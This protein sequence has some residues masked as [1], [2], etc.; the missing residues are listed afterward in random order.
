V[1]PPDLDPAAA[2]RRLVADI[3]GLA[4]SAFAFG[5]VYGLAALAAGFSPPDAIATSLIVFSGAA[6]FAA[7]GLVVA[8]AG[9][10]L[11]VITTLF[12]NLRHLLYAA[13]LR[14]SV[15]TRSAI[16]RAGMAHVLTDE[17][18]ALATVHFRRVGRP[19]AAGYWLAAIGAAFVPWNA[20]TIVGVLGGSFV[21]DPATLG[22]DVVF[23]AAMAGIAVALV[24]GRREL[25]AVV[26]GIAI[27]IGVGLVADPRV[28]I[29]AGGLLGAV[30]GMVAPGSPAALEQPP[31][32]DPLP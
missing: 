21:P 9:W 25:V 18:F 13:A 22:L 16:E 28:G 4:A 20:G 8:G 14:P 31:R 7:V 6:Q 1:N 32:G 24:I 27:A 10:P 30:V 5:V 26:A 19:D 12:L 11:I 3:G 17:A 15:A 2:R 23:P 29:V